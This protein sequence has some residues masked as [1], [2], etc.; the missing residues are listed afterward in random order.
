MNDELKSW[1][2]KEN[3]NNC[4]FDFSVLIG[5]NVY[6][7]AVTSYQIQV[8]PVR[9]IRCK[10]RCLN[11]LVNFWTIVSR[12]L[13]HD[14]STRKFTLIKRLTKPVEFVNWMCTNWG[15]LLEIILNGFFKRVRKLLLGFLFFLKFV[16]FCSKMCRDELRNIIMQLWYG[17]DMT[18]FIIYFLFKSLL[19]VCFIF[20]DSCIDLTPHFFEIHRV[21]RTLMNIRF[22]SLKVIVL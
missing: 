10:V 6:V 2:S 4:C 13:Q 12:I 7:N 1:E 5:C 20:Y 16:V 19:L 11:S 9:V 14:E 22:W 18:N 17:L 3:W 8:Q 21:F 15:S